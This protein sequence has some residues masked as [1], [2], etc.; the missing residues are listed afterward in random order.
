MIAIEKRCDDEKLDW[1]MAAAWF[2][3]SRD[4]TTF[5]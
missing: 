3:F 2:W 4:V 1:E 5:V